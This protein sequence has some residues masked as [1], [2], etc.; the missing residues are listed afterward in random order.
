MLSQQHFGKSRVKGGLGL[1]VPNPAIK[2]YTVGEWTVVPF[3]SPLTKKEGRETESS[4]LNTN[5]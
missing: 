3:L 4:P 2:G 5:I 1:E